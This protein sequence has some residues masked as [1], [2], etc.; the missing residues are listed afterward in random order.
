MG[1]TVEEMLRPAR[2]GGV[3]RPPRG[4]RDG[5]C[6]MHASGKEN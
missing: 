4:G 1:D 6:P 2:R 3:K 5:R